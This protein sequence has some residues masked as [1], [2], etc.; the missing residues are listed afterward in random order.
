MAVFQDRDLGEEMAAK[1]SLMMA[2][3]KALRSAPGA[4]KRERMAILEKQDK[5]AHR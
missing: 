5:D 1:T 4:I 2:E 3:T